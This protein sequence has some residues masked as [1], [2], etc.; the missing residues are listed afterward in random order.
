M[1]SAFARS[2]SASTAVSR[3]QRNARA[4]S[5]RPRA[6]FRRAA[7]RAETVALALDLFAVWELHG[8]GRYAT[9][10]VSAGVVLLLVLTLRRPLEIL[11][12]AGANRLEKRN[13]DLQQS[14]YAVTR[15]IET[16]VE[17]DDQK[18]DGL[19]PPRN[20]QCSRT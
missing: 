4:T 10:S 14:I 16:L 12:A 11:I 17:R 7:P 15:L 18:L 9:A 20:A 1:R 2:G 5:P 3:V 19:A 6:S 13:P 8:V